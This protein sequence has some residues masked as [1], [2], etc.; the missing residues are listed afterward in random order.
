MRVVESEAAGVIV[1]GG[2]KFT[3]VVMETVDKRVP[4]RRPVST[5]V[6]Q[7]G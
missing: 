6:W 5:Y 1:G 2:R 4:P 7:V 3:V